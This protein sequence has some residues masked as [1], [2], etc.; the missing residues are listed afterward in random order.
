MFETGQVMKTNF[1]LFFCVLSVAAVVGF[2][3]AQEKPKQKAG[4]K[5]PVK[6]TSSPSTNVVARNDYPIVGYIQKNDREITIKAAPQGTLYSV[7]NSEGKVLLENVSAE[8]LRA[9]A[10]DLHDFIK[11]AVARQ[12]GKD[13]SLRLNKLDA[14]R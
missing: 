10:P 7:K 8:Q 9:Q 2:A 12:D 13:A 5:A 4:D 1:K 11:T 3:V 6:S 14:S